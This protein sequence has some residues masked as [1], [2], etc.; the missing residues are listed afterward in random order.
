M[1]LNVYKIKPLLPYSYQRRLV[2]YPHCTYTQNNG[3]IFFKKLFTIDCHSWVIVQ[4][5]K[6]IKNSISNN[7]QHCNGTASA[8]HKINAVN[9]KWSYILFLVLFAWPFQFYVQD[10]WCNKI[11]IHTTAFRLTVDPAEMFC[12][13]IA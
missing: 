12:S 3:A 6:F 10:C 7:L 9:M 4:Y 11:N 13:L 1:Y 2:F 5:Y 8:I